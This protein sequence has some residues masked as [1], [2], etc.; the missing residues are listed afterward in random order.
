MLAAQRATGLLVVRELQC[1]QV[2]AAVPCEAADQPAGISRRRLEIHNRTLPPLRSYKLTFGSQIARWF[3]RDSVRMRAMVM[4]GRVDK[5][6][7]GVMGA[8][9]AMISRGDRGLYLRDQ[10][11]YTVPVRSDFCSQRCASLIS[12]SFISSLN[13]SCPPHP[14]VPAEEVEAVAAAAS[15]APVSRSG[16]PRATPRPATAPPPSLPV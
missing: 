2:A 13:P 16:R 14:I 4:M 9:L 1:A 8:R 7:C 11:V 6:S 3:L 15:A 12:L 10:N 5:M